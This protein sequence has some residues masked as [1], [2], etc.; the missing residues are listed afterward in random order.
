MA[1][2]EKNYHENEERVNLWLD[3]ALL[4][5]WDKKIKEHGF[6]SRAEW[7]RAKVREE[8]EK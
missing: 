6:K 8:I 3:K 4:E 5:A 1:T 7:F 2:P